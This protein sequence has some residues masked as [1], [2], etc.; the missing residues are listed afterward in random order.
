MGKAKRT[1]TPADESPANDDAKD[2]TLLPEF[3]E[4][5]KQ[6][7]QTET[8]WENQAEADNAK[9][10]TD[11]YM[12]LAH[13][14][15]HPPTPADLI[16]KFFQDADTI[17]TFADARETRPPIHYL[18][19]DPEYPAQQKRLEDYE[20]KV[21][22]H[23]R[24]TDSFLKIL[25]ERADMLADVLASIG[26]DCKPVLEFCQMIPVGPG[27]HF[28]FETAPVW[29]KL[30]E[31]YPWLDS[32][33]RRLV[34]EAANGG[35]KTEPAADQGGQSEG[36]AQGGDGRK[37]KAKRGRRKLSA[38]EVQRY[39]NILDK[40]EAMRPNG[41]DRMECCKKWNKEHPSEPITPKIIE[42]AQVYFSKYP[43]LRLESPYKPDK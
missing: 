29:A 38:K 2:A 36:K 6:I 26:E 40:W 9:K 19:G 43:A 42:N 35:A 33:R 23:A 27:S 37:G 10:L 24:T 31:L 25:H 41:F 11:R 34:A 8:N 14:L 1:P 3:A 4:L 18:K 32:I 39:R 20:G 22:D 17:L 28:L 21:A 16:G 30:R 7:A 12:A 15:Y 13:R 5:G